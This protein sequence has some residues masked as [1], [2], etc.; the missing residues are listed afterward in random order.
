MNATQLELY[1]RQ[2][3]NAIS[4]TFFTQDELWRAM[5]EAQM[6]L[7]TKAKVITDVYST[8]SV[9]SQREYDYPTRAISIARV[10]FDGLKLEQISWDEDDKITLGDTDTTATG[11]PLYYSIWNNVL[12]LRPTPS[13]GALTIKVYTYNKPR[14]LSNS[15]LTLDVPE[16]YHYDLSYFVLHY[17]AIKDTNTAMAKYYVDQWQK[18]IDNALAWQRKKDR[19]NRPRRVQ[20][21]AGN[22]FN[23]GFRG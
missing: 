1:C 11:D 17:M 5:E 13:T 4:D 14:T 3:Y 12:F 10:E 20:M 22:P 2:R 9:A 19:G 21:D 23:S 18:V 7:A 6:E 8:T 15:D 16:E